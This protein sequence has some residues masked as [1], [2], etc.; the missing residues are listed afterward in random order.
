[1]E[2]GP[3]NPLEEARDRLGYRY[4]VR[5]LEPSPPAVTH[6]PFT[7][8]PTARG[9]VPPGRTLVAPIDTGVDG[10][11]T[12]DGLARD[13]P[14][15]AAWCAP[16]ALGAWTPP[17]PLP[18]TD[19]LVRTRLA[20]HALAE[21]VLCP[22]RYR[23]NGKI[24]LRFTRGGFGTPFF[25]TDEQVRVEGRTLVLTAFS[26]ARETRTELTTLGAA[27]AA[28]GIEA[29][30]PPL[31][32]PATPLDLERRLEVDAASI[33]VFAWWFGL[34]AAALAQLRADPES[35]RP[36]SNAPS[37]VQLW[38]EHF[39][40]A[41][42]LGDTAAGTRANFGASPGDA[43]HPEPY[44]YVGPWDRSRLPDQ[45]GATDQTDPY[46][47]EPFGAS[48]PYSALSGPAGPRDTALAFFRE[49]R[50]RLAG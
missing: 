8:D 10:D 11:L 40:I 20:L 44:L 38:P 27:A 30:A 18:A 47:T 2:I 28:I 48:L 14:D 35:N 7:D 13:D 37:F 12:W 32:E 21:H 41:V 45:T 42:D 16:R 39:D 19:T 24:G 6:E 5:V 3:M 43:G 46:W 23:V 33:T 1:M 36:A 22:A 17:P 29:G 15:L 9:V 31:F 49:G 50:D 4:E 26:P 34:G 25:G